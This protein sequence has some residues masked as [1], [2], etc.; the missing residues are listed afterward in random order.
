ML[1][2]VQQQG[3]PLITL[4]LA[5]R[6]QL[7]GV[8]RG[9]GALANARPATIMAAWPIPVC[10]EAHI[11]RMLRFLIRHI[12]PLFAA[13]PLTF[14]GYSIAAMHSAQHSRLLVIDTDS[15]NVSDSRWRAASVHGNNSADVPL[16]ASSQQRSLDANSAS[17]G[18]I[19]SSQL[20]PHSLAGSSYSAA[21]AV[22][23]TWPVCTARTARWPKQL[24]PRS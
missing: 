18:S 3:T 17:M 20:N 10:T 22:V 14:A 24:A 7:S 8:I 9:A 11:Q 21:M 6:S 19:F 5:G 1:K 16:I 23:A 13:R 15:C 2:S 4:R 12:G